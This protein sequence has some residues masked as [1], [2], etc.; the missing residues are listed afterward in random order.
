MPR[1]GHGMHTEVLKKVLRQARPPQFS[2]CALG[3]TASPKSKAQ[4]PSTTQLTRALVT[5]FFEIL[6]SHQGLSVR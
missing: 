4:L 2:S 3:T 1:T 5:P 6:R